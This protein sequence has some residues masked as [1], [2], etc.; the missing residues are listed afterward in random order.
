VLS[1][2]VQSVAQIKD[3][4]VAYVMTASGVERREVTVGENNE[5]F[6]EVRAGLDEGDAVCLDARARSAA[7]SQAEKS[8]VKEQKAESK[9]Q[10]AEIGRLR[11]GARES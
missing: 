10:K 8:T 5:K 11:L 3:K 4:H 9:G 7:E 1:V 2:P 6:V